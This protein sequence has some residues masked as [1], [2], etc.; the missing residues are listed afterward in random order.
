MVRA[1]YLRTWALSIGE[2]VPDR[3]EVGTVGRQVKQGGAARLDG[4]PD[5]GD[6]VSRQIV[7]DD[8]IAWS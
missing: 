6:L 5:A 1:A 8:D 3:V 4:I 2:G 7:H